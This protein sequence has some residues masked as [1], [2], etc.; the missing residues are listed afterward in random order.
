MSAF[1]LDA[2]SQLPGTRFLLFKPVLLGPR[3]TGLDRASTANYP[4]PSAS[5]PGNAPSFSYSRHGPYNRDI[6]YKHGLTEL[7]MTSYRSDVAHETT[8]V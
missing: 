6:P 1:R 5:L 8:P 4:E 3:Y 2:G 7:G